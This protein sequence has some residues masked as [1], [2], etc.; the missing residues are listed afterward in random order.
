MT[1]PLRYVR[2]ADAEEAQIAV[3]IWSE[4]AAWQKENG[5]PYWLPEDLRLEMAEV[6]INA[7]ELILGFEDGAAR[8]CMLV[9][10]SDTI[11]WPEKAAGSALYLHRLAV[12]RSH[13]GQGWGKELITWA[14]IHAAGL[15]LRLDCAP[16]PRLMNFY[17]SNGFVPVDAGPVERG[18][19]SVIRYERR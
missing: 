3:S 6:R 10:T 17:S 7:G 9:Q 4:A 2:S 15:P 16:R 8:A 13:A 1:G 18:G 5:H 19:F 14:A 11:F 12:K